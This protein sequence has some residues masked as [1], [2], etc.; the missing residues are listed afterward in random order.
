MPM[1][2]F[3]MLFQKYPDGHLTEENFKKVFR[4]FPGNIEESDCAKLFRRFDQD[5]SGEK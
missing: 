5:N 4:N 2:I 3:K 1:H